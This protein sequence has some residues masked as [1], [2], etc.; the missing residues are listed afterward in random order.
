MLCDDKMMPIKILPIKSST[1]LSRSFANPNIFQLDNGEYFV[2]VFVPTEGNV[3]KE[4]GSLI[5]K[6]NSTEDKNAIDI[7][8]MMEDIEDKD[9]D[10]EYFYED[11]DEKYI[12]NREELEKKKKE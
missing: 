6:F 3:P 5:Y 10:L 4:V 12:L 1:G 9:S 7:N 2:S 11:E 8:N